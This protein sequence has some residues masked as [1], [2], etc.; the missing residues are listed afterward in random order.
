VGL[1][2]DAP[3]R[4]KVAQLFEE[5]EPAF[6]S[7]EWIPVGVSA[8]LDDLAAEHRRLIAAN[9]EA[10]RE[11]AGLRWRFEQEDEQRDEAERAAIRSG[12]D[13]E[14]VDLTPE[15]ERRELLGEARRRHRLTIEALQEFATGEAVARIEELA[16]GLLAE[17]AGRI[18]EAEAKRAEAARLLAE[19]ETEELAERRL[20]EWIERNS[21]LS[22]RKG[23]N[24]IPRLRFIPWPHLAT[25]RPRPKPQSQQPGGDAFPGVTSAAVERGRAFTNEEI[26]RS[27]NPHGEL[28]DESAFYRDDSDA[29]TTNPTE[30]G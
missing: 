8:E 3:E 9:A 21:G 5:G 17:V 10:A 11:H 24:R 19:A 1:S 12:G 16:P 15:D 2:V 4:A 23:F 18:A 14:P 28:R 20:Q 27:L 7:P 30:E 29:D 26:A 22:K 6:G 25:F 13:P